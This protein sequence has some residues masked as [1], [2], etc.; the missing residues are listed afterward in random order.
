M[1]IDSTGSNVRVPVA[2]PNPSLSN[3]LPVSYYPQLMPSAA[4]VNLYSQL[5][6]V[7]H[8]PLP[9]MPVPPPP[10]LY[11]PTA[12]FQP[13]SLTSPFPATPQSSN[14][15]PPPLPPP[16]PISTPRAHSSGG[17]PT[18]TAVPASPVAPNLPLL[19]APVPVPVR[20]PLPPAPQTGSVVFAPPAPQTPKIKTPRYD[21]QCFWLIGLSVL[22]LALICCDRSALPSPV[23]PPQTQGVPAPPTPHGAGTKTV[24]LLPPALP[25]YRKPYAFVVPPSNRIGYVAQ[26]PRP[27]EMS[28]P[29]S[30]GGGGGGGDPTGPPPLEADSTPSDA[31]MNLA[32]PIAVNGRRYWIPKREADV[33]G[34]T[35]G[36]SRD[37]FDD[38]PIALATAQ[39]LILGASQRTS[40]ASGAGVVAAGTGMDFIRASAA[41]VTRHRIDPAEW[42]AATAL[43]VPDIVPLGLANRSAADTP[44]RRWRFAWANLITT[45]KLGAAVTAMRAKADA[46]TAF[47]K[48]INN[49]IAA[50]AKRRANKQFKS[51][52]DVLLRTKR[53]VREMLS[54]WRKS[55]KEVTENKRRS[56]RA[57]E[58]KRKRE[59][60]RREVER[61]QRKLEFLLKQ[62]ELV[63]HFIGSKMGIVSAGGGSASAV[64]ASN[65]LPLPKAA[66]VTAAHSVIT[67]D[68]VLA[69]SVGGK[70]V[71]L[72]SEESITAHAE[73]AA[74][75]YLAQHTAKTAAF[76]RD[77]VSA[78][79]TSEAASAKW[80]A[81]QA[82]FEKKSSADT[83]AASVVTAASAAVLSVSIPTNSQGGI[84]IVPPTPIGGTSVVGDSSSS[85]VAAAA[86]GAVA[87]PS[88]SGG[89]MDLL[90][91]STLQA[92]SYVKEPKAFNGK[93]KEYQLKGLNWLVSL[94]E[95]GINGI[96]ADEMGLGKTIQ[97]IAFMA[98][99]CSVKD[100]WGPF[101]VVAPTSTVHQWQQ[102]LT[103]FAP[104]LKVLPYWGTIKE[105]KVLRRYWNP[106][107]LYTRDA[108]FH[109]LVT[110][111]HVIVADDKY[112]MKLKWQFMI[113]DEAQ[114]IKN[115]SSQ[116]W[117]VLLNLKCRNRLLLTGTPIQNNLSELWSL[118]HFIHPDFFD[119][120]EEFNEWFSKD[121][122]SHAQGDSGSKL[123]RHQLQRLH[124]IL[125]P[126]MLRR[127]K[128]DVENEMPPK[129]ELKVHCGLSQTQ[130]QYYAALQ[131]QVA[132]GATSAP[133][134]AVGG[135]TA[136]TNASGDT[137]L[138][139]G[140]QFR[141]C[142]VTLMI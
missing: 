88:G 126:F 141:Y 22:T 84:H 12:Q 135:N 125:K 140:M 105:R 106:A 139:L 127:V 61:Q 44:S 132:S 62:T 98:H 33:Q 71:A 24:P 100:I 65:T 6:S 96:L 21:V 92:E 8:Q 43:Y 23:R 75:E 115:A 36:R 30:G 64:T 121:I 50:H 134:S 86:A 40:N 117:N 57:E 74:A 83:G 18:H 3:T 101:L 46:R 80:K 112:F 95:Q 60:E 111:Y 107:Q 130:K 131:N 77:Y 123:N 142:T 25:L 113:L 82:K 10:A 118:L 87:T 78:K 39:R 28:T 109:V 15:L 7:Y 42:D 1:D 110:S 103:K 51:T 85:S 99:L 16:L 67:K 49:A 89:G 137:L 58:D 59:E 120:H 128:K 116:R 19:P 70:V 17:T 90:N 45:D 5:P 37:G 129:I 13:V 9:P 54:Y 104:A 114:A 4:I 102:E 53:G 81:E 93:L 76:E 32:I 20:R 73:A 27:M 35:I 47:S 79:T 108:P 48:R 94:Y 69:T 55:E 66:P 31:L 29:R 56:K 26:K 124:M 38:T 138:N 133:G 63:S 136:N 52:R 11:I 119:S 72:N 34:M 41:A 91:P 68:T 2:A 14:A 122:S 97:T